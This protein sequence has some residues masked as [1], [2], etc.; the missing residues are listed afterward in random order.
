MSLQPL[1][2]FAHGL[3]TLP[4][5]LGIPNYISATYR[6]WS[7]SKMQNPSPSK[8]FANFVDPRPTQ[9]VPVY[10]VLEAKHPLLRYIIENWTTHTLAFM[11]DTNIISE[12][13]WKLFFDLVHGKMLMFSFRPWQD[14]SHDVVTEPNPDLP[15]MALF[16][17][18]IE[19]GLGPFLLFLKHPP[20]GKSLSG[21]VEYWFRRPRVL[22]HE[23]IQELWLSLLRPVLCNLLN[24][25]ES[26]SSNS[27]M[28]FS[29]FKP[30]EVPRLKFIPPKNFYQIYV[31][32]AL[33]ILNIYMDKT[34]HGSFWEG[35]SLL[36]NIIFSTDP[37][38]EEVECFGNYWK[39]DHV[40]NL[41]VRCWNDKS[42]VLAGQRLPKAARIP[43]RKAIIATIHRNIKDVMRNPPNLNGVIQKFFTQ[44]FLKTL[45]DELRTS[46]M[47]AGLELPKN[48][49][50]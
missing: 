35:L 24:V 50:E 19:N 37:L 29:R 8:N 49:N 2:K 34:N 1:E 3:E 20:E 36:H 4:G 26:I 45:E 48:W 30:A 41:F 27:V 31:S 7:S 11:E 12:N 15:F 16:N 10:D 9:Q 28:Q 38:Q 33:F 43:I 17:W 14:L 22:V 18:S 23:A 42:P 21:Y 6:T 44:Q 13:E 5:S 47:D 25:P 39:L 46:F 40:H 32:Q